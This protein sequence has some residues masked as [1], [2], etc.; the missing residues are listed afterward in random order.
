MAAAAGQAAGLALGAAVGSL[1]GPGGALAG[2]AIGSS[3]AGFFEKGHDD[4]TQ[5]KLET[6]ALRVNQEQARL[7]AAESASINASRFRGALA[8]QM[9]LASMRGGSGSVARQF[10]QQAFETFLED[11]RAINAGLALSEVQGNISGA[12]QFAKQAARQSR[13]ITQFVSS[14]VGGIDL[15]KLR[16]HF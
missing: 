1:A 12:E 11:Q 2:A 14:S 6:A 5:A 16:E 10:G 4:R 8:S 15:N 7:K 9:S 13:N 3:A